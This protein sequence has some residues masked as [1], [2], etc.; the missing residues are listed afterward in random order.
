MKKKKPKIV[1][2]WHITLTVLAVLLAI[3][4]VSCKSDDEI[5]ATFDPGKGV[6]ISDFTPKEGGLNT[7]LI[8]YGDNF[9][10]DTSKIKVTI[11]GVQAKIIGV[12]GTSLYCIVPNKAYEGS[13]QLKIVDAA[14]EELA[15]AAANVKFT[16]QKKMLVTTLL[17]QTNEKGEYSVK[18]GPFGDCGGIA[19]CSWMSFDPQEP[20]HLYFVADGNSFRMIDLANKYMST[21]FGNGH[22]GMDRM[23]SITWTRGGDTMIIATDRGGDNDQSNSTLTR[24]EAFMDVNV[25]TRSK[26]CNGSAIHPVN[27]ELYYNS[28]GMGQ[29]YRYDFNTRTSEYL[30]AIQ[31]RDW[32]FNIQIHPSGNYAYIV[33]VNRHYILRT[34]YDWNRKTF[35]TPYIV[36]GEPSQQQWVDGVGKKARLSTPYQGVFVKNA[37]YEGKSDLYDFYFCDR[38]NQCIRTLTPEGKVT[39][40]AG[41]GSTGINPDAHGYIDG[42]LRKEARFHAPEGLAYDEANQCFYVGDNNNHR[43]RKIAFEE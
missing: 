15:Q 33:V 14:G 30:F 41:R 28:Y 1:K 38:D 24:R 4:V 23:R 6:V 35:T 16:Y 37:E 32:E 36:C 20:N 31:D 42:D 43:I 27:G 21:K 7:R 17:G 18:D 39:T 10:T 11:G 8:L 19:K 12:N 26:Q 40:F 29:V 3:C 25:L 9:G 2:R 22:S 13:V 34:D 5:T